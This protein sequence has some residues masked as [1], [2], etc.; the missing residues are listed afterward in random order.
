[1]GRAKGEAF[2]AHFVSF[3]S[4]VSASLDKEKKREVGWRPLRRRDIG[5][6]KPS[7]RGSKNSD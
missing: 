7:Q 1:M 3:L 2:T 6:P 5:Q 4:P